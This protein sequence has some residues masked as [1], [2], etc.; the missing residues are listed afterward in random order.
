MHLV[1]HLDGSVSGTPELAARAKS[2]LGKS[3]RCKYKL[4]KQCPRMNNV[5]IYIYIY[6]L[7]CSFMYM[8]L[9]VYMCAHQTYFMRL[10]GSWEVPR[11]GSGSGPKAESS[12]SL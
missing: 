11:D 8:R 3:A 5:C 12:I 7:L 6:I 1:R 10:F 2:A 9:C 4:A